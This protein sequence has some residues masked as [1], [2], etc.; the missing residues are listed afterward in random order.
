MHQVI[1]FLDTGADAPTCCACC[2]MHVD[3]LRSNTACLQ[4]SARL[5]HPCVLTRIQ[6]KTHCKSP[7][8]GKTL[9]SVMLIK[10]KAT[11]LHPELELGAGRRITVFLAPQ[12]ALVCQVRLVWNAHV[13]LPLIVNT[14]AWEGLGR[15]LQESVSR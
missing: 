10:E 15:H 14:A 9:I 11:A 13:A 5:V 12:V 3:I 4:I 1:A 2:A 8:A 6:H 7:G